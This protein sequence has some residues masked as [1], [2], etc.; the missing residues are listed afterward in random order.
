MRS[1]VFYVIERNQQ[2]EFANLSQGWLN[3][4]AGKHNSAIKDYQRI[5]NWSTLLKHATEVNLR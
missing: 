5:R 4:L 3:Y 2:H 1:E